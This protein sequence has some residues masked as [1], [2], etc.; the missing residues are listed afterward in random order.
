MP[1]TACHHLGFRLLDSRTG[2]Q[3]VSVV[4]SSAAPR[5][6]SPPPPHT[7]LLFV[8]LCYSNPGKPI[9]SGPGLFQNTMVRKAPA[10]HVPEMA[11]EE[12]LPSPRGD[13]STHVIHSV[14]TPVRLQEPPL[15]T[16]DK[17]KHRHFPFCLNPFQHRV[18]HCQPT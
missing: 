9:Q 1:R 4:L 15:F 10:L 12:E 11:Y 13:L 5:P 16:C 18:Q 8:G 17:T 14:M 6:P 3:H 2:R 7:H